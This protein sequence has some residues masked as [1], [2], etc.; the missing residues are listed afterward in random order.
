MPTN[1]SYLP[2]ILTF[3]HNVAKAISLKKDLLGQKILN[4]RFK[5]KSL[6]QFN[7]INMLYIIHFYLF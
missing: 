6:N 1:L 7:A 2:L 5:A 3:S 4:F